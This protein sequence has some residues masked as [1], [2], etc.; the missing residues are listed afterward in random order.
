MSRILILGATGNLGRAL[1]KQALKQDHEVSVI[2]RDPAKLPSET[3]ARLEVHRGDLTSL[4]NADLARL[5]TGRDVLINA[6]GNVSDGE[7][8]TALIDR[9]IGAAEAVA[10]PPICWFMAG[11]ALLDMGE[12]G[13]KGFELPLIPKH[14]Q[15]HGKNFERLSRSPL[16][17]RL[18]CPGPMVD[19]PP[20]GLGSMRVSLDCF[21]I[22][23]PSW[24]KIAPRILTV[25]HFIKSI[26][27]ITVPY[28]DV[29]ELML[30]NLS[31][32][33]AFSRKR[34]GIALPAGQTKHK[35]R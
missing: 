5:V 10:H 31:P 21:P 29:S 7:G 11:A 14:Y 18:C 28:E 19:E 26:G 32:G 1:V 3:I 9:I 13:P 22:R 35:R 24:T 34:I 17:W 33:G 25:P 8:F 6:A 23:P 2:V 16:D 20:I 4:S 30:S 12:T 27:Q 15:L